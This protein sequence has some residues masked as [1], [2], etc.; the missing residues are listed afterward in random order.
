MTLGS[1]GS[2]VVFQAI[3]ESLL[4]WNFFYLWRSLKDSVLLL[5]DVSF[6][7]L[8]LSGFYLSKTNSSLLISTL[9]FQRRGQRLRA[10]LSRL[11]S[12]TTRSANTSC[13]SWLQTEIS[14]WLKWRWPVQS[15]MVRTLCIFLLLSSLWL[16]SVLN[17]W[18]ILFLP[19]VA[20]PY[21]VHMD[22]GSQA[23]LW[24]RK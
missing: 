11:L 9:C 7:P 16:P 5:P 14:C 2:L 13:T 17:G 10:G 12:D 24:R 22:S 3:W 8:I 21:P 23:L 18:I 15:V 4:T 1:T 6:Y 19:R 20:M